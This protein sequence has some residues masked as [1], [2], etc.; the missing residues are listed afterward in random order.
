MAMSAQGGQGEQAGTAGVRRQRAGLG[1]CS[2]RLAMESTSGWRARKPLRPTK[3][4]KWP[5][6][7]A[8]NSQEA[9]GHT[10]GATSTI[11]LRTCCG[12]GA[13]TQLR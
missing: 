8:S 10:A 5:L 9:L 12:G 1:A 3:H 6:A 2:D 13:G 7:P 11:P 4:T